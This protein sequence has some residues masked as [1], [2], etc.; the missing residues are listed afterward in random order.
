MSPPR[1]LTKAVSSPDFIVVHDSIRL[2]YSNIQ[3]EHEI[4]TKV[5]VV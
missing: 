4:Q 2:C 3:T 5:T 1:D